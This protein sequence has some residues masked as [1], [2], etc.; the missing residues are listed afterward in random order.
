MHTQNIPVHESAQVSVVVQ[1]RCLHLSQGACADTEANACRFARMFTLKGTCMQATATMCTYN[2]LKYIEYGVYEE[3]IH[4]LS[5]N[6]IYLVQDGCAH[7]R[8]AYRSRSCRW[9]YLLS[10]SVSASNLWM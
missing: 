8:A 3:H 4:V 10:V 5:K 2:L 7:R 6:I 9:V 1:A